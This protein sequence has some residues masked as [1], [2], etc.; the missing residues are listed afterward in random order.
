MLRMSPTALTG[1]FEACLWAM[2]HY[3]TSAS[4]ALTAGRRRH[5]A[6]WYAL[7]QAAAIGWAAR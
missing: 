1:T 6:R 5:Y 4:R 7:A 2:R 3:A